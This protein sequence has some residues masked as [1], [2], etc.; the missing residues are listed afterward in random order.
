MCPLNL[1][2][3]G[4]WGFPYKDM[5]GLWSSLW[6]P[7]ATIQPGTTGRFRLDIGRGGFV[8]DQVGTWRQNEMRRDVHQEKSVVEWWHNED[9]TYLFGD[10]L[11][12]TSWVKK[13]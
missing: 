2:L 10:I 7:T 6:N 4:G 13:W 11:D 1:I 12:H 8:M 3:P 5:N 9:I